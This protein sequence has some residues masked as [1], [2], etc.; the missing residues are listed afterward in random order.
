MLNEH[1]FPP[2]SNVCQPIL[3]N[4]SETRLYQRKAASNVKLVSV[5]VS[6]VYTSSVSELVKLLNNSK[7]VCSSSATQRNVF[8]ASSVSQLIKPLNF[9][10]PVCSSKVT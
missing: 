6:P 7:P 3:F 5:H 9:S 4:V 10:K 1:D 2:L 8:N